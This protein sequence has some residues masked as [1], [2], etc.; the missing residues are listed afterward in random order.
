MIHVLAEQGTLDGT[1]DNPGYLRGFGIMP[2]ESV[3]RVATTAKLKPLT[4]PSGA[5]S[6]VS[7]VGSLQGVCAVA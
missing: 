4:V 1:S 7:A 5:G 2:A 6:G 3:R